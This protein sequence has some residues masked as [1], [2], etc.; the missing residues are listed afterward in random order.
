MPWTRPWPWSKV[1]EAHH[2]STA[3]TRSSEGEQQRT[4]F[5]LIDCVTTFLTLPDV[6]RGATSPRSAPAMVDRRGSRSAV[7]KPLASP[8]AYRL[9]SDSICRTLVGA[10]ST[11]S[12]PCGVTVRESPA[13]RIGQTSFN[14]TE[15]VMGQ[16]SRRPVTRVEVRG[17]IPTSARASARSCPSS[18]RVNIRGLPGDRYKDKK[19]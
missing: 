2:A 10:V 1:V 4:R 7:A 17:E 15:V 3:C 18:L 12:P 6:Q 9:L 11:T 14:R 16:P 5:T 13:R 19:V 8:Y